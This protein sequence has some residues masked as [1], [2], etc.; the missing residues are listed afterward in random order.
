LLDNGMQREDIMKTRYTVALS[1][2]SGI[3]LGAAAAQ[4][5]HAQ[6]KPKAYTVSEGET[7]DAAAAAAFVPVL[8]VAQSAA[9]GHTLHT[10]GGRVVTLNGP[11]APQRVAIIEW[12]SLE[13]AQAFYK[14]KAWNDLAPQLD[15]GVRTIRRY[16]VE[17]VK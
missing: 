11:A 16:V 10:K 7:L 4:G 8:D 2:L 3:A 6:A 13:Q 14:S 17:A 9:G 12:D 15:K 1:V 5:L